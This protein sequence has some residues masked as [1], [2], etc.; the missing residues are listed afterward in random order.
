MRDWNE[1]AIGIYRAIGA[2]PLEEWTTQRLTGA[3]LAALAALL[4]G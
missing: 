4:P 2:V 1:P 3:A